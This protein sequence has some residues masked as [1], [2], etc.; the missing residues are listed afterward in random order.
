MAVQRSIGLF[1]FH[2]P[3]Y[4]TR[5]ILY[6]TGE[7]ILRVLGT[8][9]TILCTIPIPYT[10]AEQRSSVFKPMCESVLKTVL[11]GSYLFQ[12]QWCIAVLH[13]QS[14]IEHG[15]CT[16]I[17]PAKGSILSTRLVTDSL[18][19]EMLRMG[20][21]TSSSCIIQG[22]P[23]C[24]NEYNRNLV[25]LPRVVDTMAVTYFK[26]GGTF[27][28]SAVCRIPSQCIDV[29]RLVSYDSA[30]MFEMRD[31]FRRLWSK[32]FYDH[33]CCAVADGVVLCKL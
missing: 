16:L 14:T 33:V 21:T 20:C 30:G 28:L 10:V 5:L 31:G 4:T 19:L 27:S 8:I 24:T 32:S 11:Q 13:N 9:R 12:M 26:D 2:A 6:D 7:G 1:Y 23:K 29:H 3:V 22:L 25:T 17:S 18:H 15:Q